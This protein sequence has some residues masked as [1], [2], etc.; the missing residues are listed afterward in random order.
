MVCRKSLQVSKPM[1]MA[2]PKS[3]I[4]ILFHV[5][6][7]AGIF[8]FTILAITN[9]FVHVAIIASCTW[10]A[11][12][13]IGVRTACKTDGSVWKFVINW[14]GCFARRQ[15]VEATL[16]ETGPAEIRFGYQFF[17]RRLFYFLVPVDKIETVDWS[18]GQATDMAGRD[19]NDWHVALW[20]DHDDVSKSE[21]KQKWGL[22]KPDQDVYIVG[23]S[24]CKAEAEILGLA[25]VTF[26]HAAGATW[27]ERIDDCTF[28]RARVDHGAPDFITAV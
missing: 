17:R 27:L 11:I 22:K 7:A 25:F 23:P 12:V 13:F 2:I 26:L 3:R 6:F 19:M 21:K 15:F 1:E 20:F 5:V 10:L 9:L 14:L 28:G 24:T 16:R 4:G 8:F 18:T